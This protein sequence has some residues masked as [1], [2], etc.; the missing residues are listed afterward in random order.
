MVTIYGNSISSGFTSGTPLV[1]IYT[2]G[3]QVWPVEESWTGPWPGPE[4]HPGDYYISWTPTSLSGVF[5]I[6]GHLYNLED[7]NGYFDDFSGTITQ[8]A[9]ISN[10]EILSVETTAKRIE[11]R[12]FAGCSYLRSANLLQCSRVGTSAFHA[13]FNLSSLYLPEC[14][15]IS[16]SAFYSC[17]QLSYIDLPNVTYIGKGAF[18]DCYAGRRINLGRYCSMVDD[19]AFYNFGATTTTIYPTIK[20]A[21]QGEGLVAFGTAVYSRYFNRLICPGWKMEDY[22]N[23]GWVKGGWLDPE[24]GSIST[25]HYISFP[26]YYSEESGWG[27]TSYDFSSVSVP[28]YFETDATVVNSSV[29][30]NVSTLISASMSQMLVLYSRAFWSCSNLTE[31]FAPKILSIKDGALRYCSKLGYMTLPVCSEIGEYAFADCTSLSYVMIGSSSCTL[32]TSAFYSCPNLTSI[33]VPSK[34]VS[35]YKSST[36]WSE[37]SDIIYPI[38]N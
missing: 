25:Y 13:C 23:A 22:I 12:A 31:L 20:L 18:R 26:G 9:F 36:N 38:P 35:Y 16:D 29:F 37:Y 10:A 4:V 3:C 6:E 32:S 14:T 5:S 30:S 11:Y 19:Y 27:I 8:N 33:Y 21:Y 15:W 7:Y 34:K 1:A 2:Y 17:R 28:S 24:V